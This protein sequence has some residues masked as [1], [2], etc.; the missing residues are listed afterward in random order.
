MIKLKMLAESNAA[1]RLSQ[2]ISGV[3]GRGTPSSRSTELI[4][5]ISEVA[6]DRVLYSAS[7][8]LLETVLLRA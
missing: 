7:V 2:N 5:I 4:H 6:S 3:V 1:D 8:E